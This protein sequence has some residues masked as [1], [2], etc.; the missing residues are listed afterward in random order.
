MLGALSAI[1][2]PPKALKHY[3]KILI[4]MIRETGKLEES[5]QRERLVYLLVT[6]MRKSHLAWNRS[7]LAAEQII[8]D[9]LDIS[10]GK[11]LLNPEMK[12]LTE[13]LRDIHSYSQGQSSQS[14]G[15][16]GHGGFSKKKKK[17]G[18]YKK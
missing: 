8:Q 15:R 10:E 12:I 14:H 3:G 6:Q 1:V 18:M 11:I 7:E 13:P 17:S 16:G 2:Y 5:P 4:E 9:F